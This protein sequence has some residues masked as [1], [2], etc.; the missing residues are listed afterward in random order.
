MANSGIVGTWISNNSVYISVEF[1][2]DAITL[3]KWN[4]FRLGVGVGGC[5]L[6]CGEQSRAM[7]MPRADAGGRARQS[8]QIFNTMKFL[9]KGGLTR[10]SC[11][12]S[13]AYYYRLILRRM[14]QFSK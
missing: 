7:E 12:K 9:G 3:I 5:W 6:K 13:L 8:N 11:T 1:L 2:T 14:V 10:E 4:D